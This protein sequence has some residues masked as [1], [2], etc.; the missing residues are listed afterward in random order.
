MDPKFEGRGEGF[1]RYAGLTIAEIRTRFDACVEDPTMRSISAVLRITR[2]QLDARG[3]LG[4]YP[5]FAWIAAAFAVVG[6]IGRYVAPSALHEWATKLAIGASC[7][8]VLLLISVVPTRHARR[9]N[10]LQEQAIREA[11]TAALVQILNEG[12]VLKELTFDQEMTVKILMK[13]TAGSEKL[14]VLLQGN[15]SP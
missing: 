5:V 12:P 4:V 11:A 2:E 3:Q 14:Q 13:K 15:V 7:A 9:G 1:G 10:L 6:L 8:F